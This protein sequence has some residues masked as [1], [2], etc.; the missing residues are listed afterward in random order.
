MS[1]CQRTEQGLFCTHLGG[2]GQQLQPVHAHQGATTVH[3]IV[4]SPPRMLG[5]DLQRLS[6]LATASKACVLPLVKGA[7]RAEHHNVANDRLFQLIQRTCG[8]LATP[9]NTQS[10]S[11]S[12]IH[13]MRCGNYSMPGRAT[14]AL[15]LGEYVYML[16]I[17]IRR[18]PDGYISE[19]S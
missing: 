12:Q 14:C 7:Q 2:N 4:A 9:N 1:P 13:N 18:V 6:W 17:C 3:D 8:R 19:G 5:L 10:R 16:C 15:M 11:T